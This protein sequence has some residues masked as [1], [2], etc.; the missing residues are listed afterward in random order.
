MPLVPTL[1]PKERPCLY[2]LIPKKAF[3]KWDELKK[4]LKASIHLEGHSWEE[5][6]REATSIFCVSTWSVSTKHPWRGGTCLGSW[7]NPL[8][9]RHFSADLFNYRIAICTQPRH[10]LKK[11]SSQSTCTSSLTF[12]LPSPA[13]RVER[14]FWTSRC[15]TWGRVNIRHWF[16]GFRLVPQFH[17][18]GLYFIQGTEACD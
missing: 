4:I 11:C 7:K 10:W 6:G 13:G 3:T 8:V 9:W 12:S 14:M 16:E 15:R 18:I 17:S 5:D 1:L 2:R